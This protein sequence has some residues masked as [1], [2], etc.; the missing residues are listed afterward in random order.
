MR[1]RVITVERDSFN[2]RFSSAA[3]E[4]RNLNPSRNNGGEKQHCG[5]GSG[6][7]NHAASLISAASG[8]GLRLLSRQHERE[9]NKCVS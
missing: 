2:R 3:P 4:I 5:D 7:G 6:M 9:Q 1:E 8:S